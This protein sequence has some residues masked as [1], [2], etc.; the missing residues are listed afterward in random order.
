VTIGVQKPGQVALF[1]VFIL[2]GDAVVSN[3]GHKPALIVVVGRGRAETS[4]AKT[5]SDPLFLLLVVI[6]KDVTAF[7]AVNHA[8]GLIIAEAL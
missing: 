7:D 1:I 5:A 4:R 6:G 8:P 2:G 3:R